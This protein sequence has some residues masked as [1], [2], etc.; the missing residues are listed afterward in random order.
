MKK[1]LLIIGLSVVFTAC[2]SDIAVQPSPDGIEE[3]HGTIF[4]KV[5][6]M[7]EASV[8]FSFGT[9]S[10]LN[11]YPFS[12]DVVIKVLEGDELIEM[13]PEEAMLAIMSSSDLNDYYFNFVLSSDEV[14][15]MTQA[16]IDVFAENKSNSF[17][18]SSPMISAGGVTD[19]DWF[20]TVDSIQWL[21]QGTTC[22]TSDLEVSE[23]AVQLPL[24]NPNGFLILNEFIEGKVLDVSPDV[25]VYTTNFG[26]VPEA[27]YEMS[28]EDFVTAYEAQKDYFL[29]ATFEIGTEILEADGTEYE[30]VTS[31]QEQ[32]I[33]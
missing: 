11:T 22:A 1:F 32:Y 6:F 19:G 31:I 8:Q 23:D 20:L 17:Y 26:A 18:I 27:T 5:D 33:P 21:G 9:P 25:S 4:A 15:Q 13:S 24:C 12:E 16:D 2:A 7:D 29:T 14:L 10:S 3:D 28:F 30:R